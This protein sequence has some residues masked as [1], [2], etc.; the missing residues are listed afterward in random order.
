MS[1][2]SHARV[3]LQR[4][5]KMRPFRNCKMRLADRDDKLEIWIC[6]GCK[7]GSDARLEQVEIACC[8]HYN[9]YFWPGAAGGIR[10]LVK[11]SHGG[12]HF[13]I[14][15]VAAQVFFDSL[16]SRSPCIRLRLDG[17]GRSGRSRS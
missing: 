4:F 9:A 3:Q 11:L 2:N 5:K 1:Q 6:R 12:M 7:K 14:D 13:R 15:V 8:R 10:N 17:F 16:T